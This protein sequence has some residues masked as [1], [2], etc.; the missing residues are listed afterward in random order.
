[1]DSQDEVIIRPAG[2]MTLYQISFED[3]DE[4]VYLVQLKRQEAERLY[5]VLRVMLGKNNPGPPP[6]LAPIQPNPP[7]QPTPNFSPLHNN[8]FYNPLNGPWRF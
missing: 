4:D 3:V 2:C 6:I 1:M 8:P 7:F 5:E